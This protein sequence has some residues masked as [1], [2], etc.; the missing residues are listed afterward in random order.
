M[1]LKSFATVV[2]ICLLFLLGCT[3]AM[4]PS[5]KTIN[6]NFDGSTIVD[7]PPVSAASRL[8]EGWHTLGFTWRTNAPDI[9]V[10]TVGIPGITNI[11]DVSFNVDGYFLKN[12]K[13]ASVLT[14]YGKHNKYAPNISHRTFAISL[15]DFLKIA[16]GQDVKIR[17]GMIDKYSVSSFG[18]K[19][20]GAA[21]NHKF[22]PFKDKIAELRK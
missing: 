12:I 11:S 10:L 18:A 3:G 21:V 17:V 9:V 2:G 16:N 5:L 22:E 19:N 13:A 6:D 14:D 8:S 15:D 1:K 20:S 7:Q 4:T